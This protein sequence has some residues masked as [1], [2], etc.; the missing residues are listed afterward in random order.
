[1]G[2]HLRIGTPIPQSHLRRFQDRQTLVNHLRNVTYDLDAVPVG[3]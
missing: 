2:I 3:Q 1:M